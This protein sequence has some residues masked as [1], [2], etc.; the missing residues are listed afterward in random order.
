MCLPLGDRSRLAGEFLHP[1]LQIGDP[2]VQIDWRW[3]DR[4]QV[5]LESIVV[6]SA[7]SLFRGFLV[8]VTARNTGSLASFTAM[9][10]LPRLVQHSPPGLPAGT[11]SAA[12]A[13]AVFRGYLT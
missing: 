1:R 2:V 5:A 6:E 11:T 12:G 4:L 9:R 7:H 3:Y 8:V 10:C 13:F